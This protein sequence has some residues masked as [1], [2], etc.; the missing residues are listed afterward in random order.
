MPKS[1]LFQLV[2]F[3]LLFPTINPPVILSKFTVVSNLKPFCPLGRG[4]YSLR[5]TPYD[6]IYKEA[7]PERGTF[8]MLQVYERVGIS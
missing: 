6:G 2:I 1:L 5:V 3:L 4:K 7:L 8:F